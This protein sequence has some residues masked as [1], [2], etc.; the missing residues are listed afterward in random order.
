MNPRAQLQER[1]KRDRDEIIGLVRDMVRVPSENPPGDTTAIHAFVSDYLAK[2]G[3]D[4]AT[5][6]PQPTMP[7][8]VAT[9]DGGEPGK[10]LVLNGHMDV[11]PAGNHAAWSDPPFSGTIRDDKLFGRGV[12][13]MKTG[14]SASILTYCYL[15]EMRQ[16]L[17][18]SLVLTAVSDEETFGAWGTQ[19]LL[20]NNPEV[21]GDCVL[22]G[23][24]STP[25]VVRFGEKGL[26][27]IELRVDTQGGV[28]AHPHLFPSAIKQATAIIGEL[29]RLAEYPATIPA[30]VSEA[31]EAARVDYDARVGAGTTDRLRSVTVNVGTIHGGNKVNLIPADCTLEVDIRCPVGVTTDEILARLD[32]ILEHYPDASY[33][34]VHRNDPNFCDP[35]HP[36][37]GIIQRNAEAVRGFAPRPNVSLAGTDC[38][39]WRMRGIPAYV[40]GPSP[41]NMGAPD[42]H[43]T[44]DDL[45]GTVHVHVLS[46]YD[47]LMS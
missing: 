5:I 26:L 29:D 12:I 35:G 18:G 2:R 19:Y 30:E 3:L 32:G 27:W 9:F 25:N 6:A 42:E 10:R 17:R 21:M 43:V 31:I 37:L 36:M 13:D 28:A 33:S 4:H 11:F 8:I 24:P 15:A 47:Y 7:N 14:T 23:E 41:N 16:H 40:Y 38:R 39:F 45:L 1:L 22:N 44:L 46:A 20:A 34:I